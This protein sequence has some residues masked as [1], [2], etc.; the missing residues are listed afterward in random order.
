MEL[1]ASGR[2]TPGVCLEPPAADGV[3]QGRQV[4]AAV[5]LLERCVELGVLAP[6]RSASALAARTAL[7]AAGVQAG[8]RITGRDRVDAQ[9]RGEFGRGCRW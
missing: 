2:V 9:G 7:I 3:E 1:V 6:E 8:R 5:R 4:I